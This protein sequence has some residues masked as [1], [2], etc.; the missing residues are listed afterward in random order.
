[1]KDAQPYTCPYCEQ[2]IP[3]GKERCPLCGAALMESAEM[4]PLLM[5]FWTFIAI[6]FAS[7]GG[8]FVATMVTMNEWVMWI[9]M[10]LVVIVNVTA[11]IKFWLLR[12]YG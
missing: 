11:W 4:H 10:A 5:M 2:Q 8:C 12:K 6:P 1:M 9:C 3:S 7:I